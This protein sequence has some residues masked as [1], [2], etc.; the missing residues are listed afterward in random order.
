MIKTGF[1]KFNPADRG[2]LCSKDRLK[3]LPPAKILNDIGLK[4]GDS[5]V[6]IGCGPGVFALAAASIVGPKGIV[7]GLDISSEMI[8]ELKKS[9]TSL[10]L[11]NVR[12]ILAKEVETNLPREASFYFMLNV[13]H[14]LADRPASLRNIRRSMGAGSRL[15][16]ID[17]FRKKTP[18]GPPLS[19]RVPLKEAK[20]LLGEQGLTVRKTWRAN[21]D[22][23]GLVAGPAHP[24]RKS[25][26]YS[27]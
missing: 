5:L 1:H 25:S 19:E 17:Y 12:A 11:T 14:E 27:R 9:A 6:D 15:A 4:S 21:E 26:F 16:I 2:R 3:R 24:D 20:S 10:G 23:Y 8:D 13:F 7:F 22:E 18:H